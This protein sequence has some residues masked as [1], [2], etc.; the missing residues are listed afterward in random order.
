MPETPIRETLQACY[1]DHEFLFLE[2]P[3]LD[4]AI[5]GVA[6]R[7][8]LPVLV[9]DRERIVQLA[10]DGGIG[11]LD[12]AE[13]FVAFNIEGG[14]VGPQTP[15]TIEAVG[16][17]DGELEALIACL[18][19]DSAQIREAAQSDQVETVADEWAD[20]MDQAASKLT[21]CAPTAWRCFH[22]GEAFLDESAAAEHFGTRETQDPA[23]TIDVAEYRRMEET[24]RQHRE[25]DTA[26]HREL[27]AL[28]GER[29]RAV[30]AAE[31]QGYARGMADVTAILRELVLAN[32]AMRDLHPVERS[33]T[34]RGQAAQQ[35]LTDAWRAANK[36]IGE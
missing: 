31:E 32:R 5:V 21:R 6:W 23:C 1:P 22:C 17:R 16:E 33:H 35:R 2:P 34:A 12:D 3:E 8:S 20:T 9:Y 30:K 7:E 11:D 10:K 13:E 14:H 27:Y 18:G 15:I 24:D 28:Q 26:L 19:D 25:E 4:A 36:V 29:D